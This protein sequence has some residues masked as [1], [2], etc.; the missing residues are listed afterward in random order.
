[1][2]NLDNLGLLFLKS[3]DYS[4]FS[5]VYE[6]MKKFTIASFLLIGLL[7]VVIIASLFTGFEIKNDKKGE[8]E[9]SLFWGLVNL[10]EKDHTV[11]TDPKQDSK[12]APEVKVEI[13]T[14]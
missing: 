13:E 7:M 9:V 12:Q 5:R 6:F 8:S 3:L 1:M 11:N 14:Y 10:N 2:Q 4:L